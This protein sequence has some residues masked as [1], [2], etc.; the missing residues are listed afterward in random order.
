MKPSPQTTNAKDQRS[1]KF[2]IRKLSTSC[3]AVFCV[4]PMTVAVATS[5][6]QF[7]TKAV[8]TITSCDSD[9]VSGFAT[10]KERASEEGIKEV[11]VFIQMTGLG[12]SQRAVHIHE[13]ASCVPCSSAGGHFDPG[14]SGFSS[15]DGNHPFHSGDLPQITSRNN[16]GV[17]ESVTSRLSL[18]SGPLSLFD[19]DGSAF[20]VHDNPDTYCFGGEVAGC[21]GGSRAACGIIT[22]VNLSDD[23]ELLVSSRSSRRGSTELSNNEL[24]G[25]AYVFLTP[26]FPNEPVTTVDF[27]ID[28][29]PSKTEL[30]A[31]F[32]LVGTRSYG[33]AAAFDTRSLGDGTH[34]VSAVINLSSGEQTFVSSVFTV[35]NEGKVSSFRHKY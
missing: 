14:L 24:S 9:A 10:L 3:I 27:F 25:Y 32:D 1:L 26:I 8:A 34:T 2:F 16:L 6:S 33:R 5:D 28:G 22:P 29:Q 15:P 35:D 31:P 30:Y 13:T 11:E 20:I 21:A 18:S 23:F 19:S 12:D 4:L 17:S 7:S